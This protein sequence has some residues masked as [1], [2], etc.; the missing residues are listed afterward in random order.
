MIG[1]RPRRVQCG[2][3]AWVC[4]G[5]PAPV[6]LRHV[7]LAYIAA[8]LV[9][10]WA[11]LVVTAQLL[12]PD[13]SPLSMGMSGLARGRSPWV[14]KS[15]FIVRGLSALRWSRRCRRSCAP[16]A[17]S[18]SARCSSGCG[19]WGPPRS[20][21]PTPTC[22]A[23]PRP[24]PARRTPLIALVAYVAGA[25]GAD[26]P[27]GRDAAHGRADRAGRLGAAHRCDGSR[28]S[29]RAV[30]RLRRPGARG[31]LDGRRHRGSPGPPR[32]APAATSASVSAATSASVPA[33]ASPPAPA[34]PAAGVPPQLGAALAAPA[35]PGP[36]SPADR[37]R[38]ARRLGRPPARPGRLRRPL[39]ACLRRAPHGLDAPRRP[40]RRAVR[41]R[42]S[43]DPRTMRGYV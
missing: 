22:P 30:R 41:T 23:S 32:P 28:R 37:A 43:D 34:P 33:A 12:N 26:H 39:P 8:A 7:R 36:R 25:A 42:P 1:A 18:S 16:R 5:R 14:M 4:P 29:R 38:E 11:A 2:S 3:G 13:Q 35:A 10:A 19:G 27:L 6:G 40:R 24:P 31:A 15:S 17:W 21:S 20:R 9:V